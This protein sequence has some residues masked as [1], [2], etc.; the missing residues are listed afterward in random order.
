MARGTYVVKVAHEYS[1]K[2]ISGLVLVH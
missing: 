1:G 2:V